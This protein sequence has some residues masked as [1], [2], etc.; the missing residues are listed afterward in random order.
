MWSRRW[1]LDPYWFRSPKSSGWGS[2][3]HREVDLGV[4]NEATRF[5]GIGP[6]VVSRSLI[7]SRV[8]NLELASAVDKREMNLGITFDLKIDT[9]VIKIITLEI[10]FD[11]INLGLGS[12][13]Y[14][15]V[16]TFDVTKLG[17]NTFVVNFEISLRCTELLSLPSPEGAPRSNGS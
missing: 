8:A 12:A 13:F 3:V 6:W 11:V 10:T 16:I 4:H 5:H 17:I 2:W 15:M 1:L 9:G 14:K 7:Y